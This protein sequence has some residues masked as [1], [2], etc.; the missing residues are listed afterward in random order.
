MDLAELTEAAPE[1][2]DLGVCSAEPFAETR[3]ELEE[4]KARGEAGRLTFTYNRPEIST[5]I[6]QS[7]PWAERLVVGAVSYLPAAGS[8]GESEPGSARVAR[9]ATEDHYRPLRTALNRLADLMIAK[10][11]QAQ[12][13]VDDNRLVDRAAAARAGI[14]WW[15][16]NSM[17]LTPRFGPWILLGSI[18]TD[19]PLPVTEPMERGCGTCTACIPSC[20]TGAIVRPGVIDARLCLAAILQA[21]GDIP[22][23]LR[24]AVDDRLYGC[25]DCLE[26]CPPGER[27]LEASTVPRGRV[28][29]R[30]IL[31][32][33]NT[34]LLDEFAR[35]YIPRRDPDYL[36]RNALVVL[37]NHPDPEAATSIGGFLDH[38]FLGEYARWAL[39]QQS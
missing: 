9:F 24:T 21:P 2:I 27:L 36:R 11:G 14:G 25:D 38:P 20:P 18:A 34:E 6:R 3:V 16:K 31:E 15:G 26:A 13:L 19:L 32:A 37:G 28:A 35:F 29:A 7:F 4:R 12:V 22:L 8:P 30:D 17:V 33:S 10:G 23:E 1:L 39:E 5:D